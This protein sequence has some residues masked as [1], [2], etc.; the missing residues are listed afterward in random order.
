VLPTC[1]GIPPPEDARAWLL[2]WTSS[3][4]TPNHR[5]KIIRV[6]NLVQWY[7]TFV[8]LLVDQQ[9]YS[10]PTE[11]N[12]NFAGGDLIYFAGAT[13]VILIW[14]QIQSRLYADVSAYMSRLYADVF[15]SRFIKA[16]FISYGLLGST[17]S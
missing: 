11:F 2:A 7:R 17:I 14:S 13:R 9:Y 12:L 6:L 4:L 3:L 5:N 15:V 16:G 10:Y 8:F 1:E